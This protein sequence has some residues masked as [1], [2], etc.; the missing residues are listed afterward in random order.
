VITHQQ[1]CH[2][3]QIKITSFSPRKSPEITRFSPRKSPEITSISQKS[4]KKSPE[5]GGQ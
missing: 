2:P 1:G 4:P 3:N 5:I